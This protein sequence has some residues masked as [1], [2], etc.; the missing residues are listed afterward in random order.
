[1]T[2]S[3][4]ECRERLKQRILHLVDYEI[5]RTQNKYDKAYSIAQDKARKSIGQARDIQDL[6]ECDVYSEADIDKFVE[7][8]A[9]LE[10]QKANTYLHQTNYKYIQTDIM[11][12]LIDSTQNL[13]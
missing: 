10:M 2:V 8:I 3:I 5:N 9:Y 13:Q 11:K 12:F 1:M 6:K 4:E 7:R